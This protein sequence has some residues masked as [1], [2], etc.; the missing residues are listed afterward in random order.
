MAHRQTNRDG[1]H[2]RHEL[3]SAND[4]DTAHREVLRRME[5]YG[6]D[7]DATLQEVARD[8]ILLLRALNHRLHHFQ[9]QIVADI[10][11][12]ESYNRTPRSQPQTGIPPRTA[13][14]HAHHLCLP[15]RRANPN[16]HIQLM[17]TKKIIL[18]PYGDQRKMKK[19]NPTPVGRPPI[20][21]CRTNLAH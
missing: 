1:L 6:K 12:R 11:I 19:P 3:T 16:M 8:T 17:Q 7:P 20:R 21:R 18:R 14:A 9:A 5:T 2:I 4:S 13:I 15:Q 10:K